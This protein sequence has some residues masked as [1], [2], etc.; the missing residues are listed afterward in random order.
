MENIL[1]KMKEGEFVF[2]FGWEDVY[3][4]MVKFKL[5]FKAILVSFV[6]LFK[7]RFYLF[8][9]VISNCIC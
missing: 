4:L 6:Y 5:D 3:I 7:V 8:L 1:V 9:C 2:R